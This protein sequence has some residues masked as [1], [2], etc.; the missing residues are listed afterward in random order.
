MPYHALLSYPF[1]FIPRS[2]NGS[3]RLGAKSQQSTRHVMGAVDATQMVA[4]PT[5]D[6]DDSAGMNGGTAY[7]NGNGNSYV[8]DV[9]EDAGVSR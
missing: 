8:N 9:D 7:A 4:V 3:F 5:A 2:T 1:L 6:Y